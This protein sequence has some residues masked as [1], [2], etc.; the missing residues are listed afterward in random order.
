VNL[1]LYAAAKQCVLGLEHF[2]D[3]P[4]FRTGDVGETLEVADSHG[5]AP[6]KRRGIDQYYKFFGAQ[7][8]IV[9]K[10]ASRSYTRDP[11]VDAVVMQTTRSLF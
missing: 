1:F 5:T 6:G 2:I 11:K 9:Q 10:L 3:F 4:V 8:G 7:V